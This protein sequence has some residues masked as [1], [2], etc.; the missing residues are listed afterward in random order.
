[1]KK[2]WTLLTLLMLLLALPALAEDNV[3][4]LDAT[5]DLAAMAQGEK[6]DGDTEVAGTEGFF[7]IHYS[8]KTKVDASTKA[9]DDGYAASQ[10]INMGGATAVGDA[11]KNAIE[12]TTETESTV[13][14]WWVCG[15]D[16]RE[17]NIYAPDGTVL[18]T[19]A[20]GCVKNSLYISTFE[21]TEA[22]KYFIGA[23]NSNYYFK[24]EV[25]T[26]G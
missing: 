3:H 16:G 14:I 15:G 7:T 2:F 18:Q 25:K 17:I 10:R 21:I 22:G 8:A 24:V 12:F 9:F 26:Q 20:E 13:K 6:A 19:T 5:A 11:I 1:M 4:V 23:S